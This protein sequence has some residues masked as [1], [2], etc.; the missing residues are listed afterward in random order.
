M[1]DELIEYTQYHFYS[2]EILMKRYKYCEQARAAHERSHASFRAK[3]NEIRER[4]LT[5]KTAVIRDQ[6]LLFLRNWLVNHILYTDKKLCDFII[7]QQ[8][9]RHYEPGLLE[10]ILCIAP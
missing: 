10:K 8:K 9:Q 1:L 3:I 2:E 6:L 4:F 7:E 5:E